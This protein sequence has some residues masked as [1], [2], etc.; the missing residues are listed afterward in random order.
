MRLPRALTAAA[1]AIMLAS[2]GCQTHIRMYPG[3]SRDAQS[4]VRIR[5][6]DYVHVESVDGREVKELLHWWTSDTAYP[7]FVMELEPGVHRVAVRYSTVIPSQGHW[8]T[9][10]VAN[11]Q[12]GGANQVYVVDQPAYVEAISLWPLTLRHNF[13]AGKT[14]TFWLKTMTGPRPQPGS[15]PDAAA[16]GTWRPMLIEQGAATPLNV[17]P[18]EL[19]A[20][21]ALSNAG[22][23]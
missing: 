5:N 1:A 23:K 11:C 12:G 19:S 2:L 3:E 10:G 17:T 21:G 6:T 9:I 16:D 14:Y 13:E 20:S 4:V 7:T 22:T 15:G 18:E 8:E